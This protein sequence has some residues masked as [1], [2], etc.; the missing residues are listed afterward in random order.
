MFAGS[1]NYGSGSGGS[2]RKKSGRAA[3]PAAPEPV[4]TQPDPPSIG[5]LG[6][7]GEPGGYAGG[8]GGDDFGSPMPAPS[9]PAPS[10]GG[11]DDFGVP[12]SAPAPPSGGGN[13]FGRMGSAPAPPSGG[14]N[15][16]GSPASGLAAMLGTPMATQN[17]GVAASPPAMPAPPPPNPYR[18]ANGNTGVAGRMGGGNP[19]MQLLLQMMQG[20]GRR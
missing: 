16:F 9:F 20:M 14:G 2:R 4:N 6:S 13:D 8:G 15:E 7:Y 10:A 1:A 11:G 18:P 12:M 3:T 19:L 5:D 17:Y